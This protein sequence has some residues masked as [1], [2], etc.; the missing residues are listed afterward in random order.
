MA[1][2]ARGGRERGREKE[3]ERG[4]ERDIRN[5]FFKYVHIYQLLQS[6][7]IPSPSDNV[8]FHRSHLTKRKEEDSCAE[9]AFRRHGAEIM[10]ALRCGSAG[11]LR[12]QSLWEKVSR[13]SGSWK[14]VLEG[15]GQE[16]TRMKQCHA[17]KGPKF[18][19]FQQVWP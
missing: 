9:L 14:Y 12:N 16:I 18:G 1:T 13:W 17:G 5:R 4:R 19:L 10:S 2:A 8:N 6:P 7:E 11:H 15:K 3:R